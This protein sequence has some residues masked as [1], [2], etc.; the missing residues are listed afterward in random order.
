MKVTIVDPK[1]D[2]K[3]VKKWSKGLEKYLNVN[4]E[5]GSSWKVNIEKDENSSI[6]SPKVSLLK[7]GTESSWVFKKSFFKSKAYKDM[8]SHG[9]DMR[10]M[11]NKDSHFEINGKEIPE[12]DYADLKQSKEYDIIVPDNSSIAFFELCT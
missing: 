1:V 6:F 2:E 12:M 10:D 7:H 8:A 5:Q 4:A 11:F 9:S 3:E